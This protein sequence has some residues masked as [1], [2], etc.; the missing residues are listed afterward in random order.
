LAAYRRAD[1]GWEH[2]GTQGTEET[3]EEM[4]VIKDKLFA[5]SG[6]S[7]MEFGLDDPDSPDFNFLSGSG[8][9]TTSDVAL[10]NG[11]L[12]ILSAKNGSVGAYDVIR[13]GL[14]SI[15]DYNLLVA[16]D[17][18][19]VGQDFWAVADSDGGVRLIGVK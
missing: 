7:F 13:L 16:P 1:A 4:V 9:G 6:Y 3:L 2:T 19:A 5:S 8:Y 12:L 11:Q 17:Q 14:D 15:G 18:V 10:W